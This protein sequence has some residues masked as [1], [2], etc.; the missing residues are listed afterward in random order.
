MEYL[1]QQEINPEADEPPE[2][3]NQTRRQIY[4]FM[5]RDF[6]LPSIKTKAIRRSYLAAVFRNQVARI[7]KRQFEIYWASLPIRSK[8]TAHPISTGLEIERLD[9]LLMQRNEPR[10]GF[11]LGDTA[12]EDWTTKAIKWFDRQNCLSCFIEPTPNAEPLIGFPPFER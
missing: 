12:I 3:A 11:L 6:I 10:I 9:N 5:K 2:F 1:Q 7:P 4:T 8:I